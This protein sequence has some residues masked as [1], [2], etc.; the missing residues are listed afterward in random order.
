MRG[1]VLTFDGTSLGD[2]AVVVDLDLGAGPRNVEE[3]LDNHFGV[4]G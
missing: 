3:G 1:K 4:A 2:I